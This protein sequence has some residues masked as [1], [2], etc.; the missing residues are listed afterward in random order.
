[1]HCAKNKK[2]TDK[3][4]KFAAFTLAEVLITLGIIGVVAAL[5]MPALISN[6]REHASV[7]AM[8]KAY[9]ILS[10]ATHSIVIDNPIEN[11]NL[12]DGNT[13]STK[14]FFEYYKPYLNITQDCGCAQYVTGCWSKDI[15]KALGG[16]NYAYAR[17]NSIGVDSCA[18]RLS[19]GMN[20]TFTF[21]SSTNV[22]VSS[23][24]AVPAFYVDVNGDT[25]PNILGRDVFM[26]AL[27]AESNSLY[28]AGTTNNSAGCTGGTSNTAGIN[29]AAKVLQEGKI[30][31]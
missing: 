6:A 18:I 21:W 9:S 16:V 8:K 29:C 30:N 27:T 4:I 19:D 23:S 15:T 26:F 1:M 31:Y 10:Q 25:K 3:N 2:S 13:N 28:P 12:A 14:E 20:V 17:A 22:G 11:W 24:K 7:T 5:T